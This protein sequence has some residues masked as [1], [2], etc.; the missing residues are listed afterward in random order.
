M[1][2]LRDKNKQKNKNKDI[3]VMNKLLIAKENKNDD[4][5]SYFKEAFSQI[6]NNKKSK[7]NEKLAEMCEE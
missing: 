1:N 6:M 2:I 4:L 3:L 5:E 7:F